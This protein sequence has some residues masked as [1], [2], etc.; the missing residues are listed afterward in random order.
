MIVFCEDCG[1]RN[2]L[3]R[4]TGGSQ[5]IVFTC[6]QCGYPNNYAAASPLP[7]TSPSRAR[8]KLVGA[9]SRLKGIDGAFVFS[10]RTGLLAFCMPE[11]VTETETAALGR[12][13]ALTY[14]GPRQ[15][16]IGIRD[17]VLVTDD[18]AVLLK[19][20]APTSFLA[21]VSAQ[22]PLAGR[23]MA[24]LNTLIAAMGKQGP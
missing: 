12:Q 22:F 4:R 10:N 7:R 11:S 9:I 18:T 6:T 13:L 5:R 21:V 24:E 23:V 2:Q 19:F 1:S 8:E 20:L 3:T 15:G 14:E 17:M 16:Y